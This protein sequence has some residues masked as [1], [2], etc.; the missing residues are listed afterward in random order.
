[1]RAEKKVLN[2]K[3]KYFFLIAI[4]AMIFI[5]RAI[6]P[7]YLLKKTNQYLSEFSPTYKLH[8]QD[9]DV[10]FIRGAYRFEGIT[11]EL[12]DK[13]KKQFLHVN[14]VDVSIAWREI[15]RGKIVT[16]VVVDT[17]DFVVI[18]DIKKLVTKKENAKDAKETLFPVNIEKV[19][20]K[21]TDITF[22]EYKSID[23]KGKMKINDINGEL[24]NL[25]P[26]DKMPLSRFDLTAKVLGT[27]SLK[28]DGNLRTLD[29]PLGWNVDAV[30]KGLDL[31]KFNP[32]LKDKL[33]LTFTKGTLDLYAE[34]KSRKGK[35]K[36]YVKPFLNNLDIVKNEGED[37]KGVKHFG[38]EMLTAIGNLILRDDSKGR[39]VAS[40]VDF[41][42]DGKLN[43]AVAEGV[44]KA[45]KH[46]M[47][48]DDDPEEQKDKVKR[49]VENRI[50]ETG[51]SSNE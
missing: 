12:K 25:S 47:A 23:G 22:D 1:M 44:K 21:N 35:V 36:G 43:V 13:S 7:E 45:I 33:P 41:T 9:F 8:L 24:K 10:S 38:I 42:Y 27:S 4:V 16:D 14:E 15:F 20:V 6:L 29:K 51:E 18:K 5:G 49:G 40:S 28:L 32:I 39:S 31:P 17:L 3:N 30:A 26:T 19:V 50:G 34:A 46:G 2:I 11:G 37:F 48:D